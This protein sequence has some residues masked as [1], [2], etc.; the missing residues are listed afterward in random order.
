MAFSWNEYKRVPSPEVDWHDADDAT[1]R[2]GESDFAARHT[3]AED[4]PAGAVA[5]VGRRLDR[6]RSPLV[7]LA[8]RAD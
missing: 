2:G 1:Q 4:I 7:T 8:Q 3:L 6:A 5:A